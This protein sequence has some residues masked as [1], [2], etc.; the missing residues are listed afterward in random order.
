MSQLHRFSISIARLHHATSDWSVQTPL[1][2]M[3]TA[4]INGQG[5]VL[6]EYVKQ[7]LEDR[8]LKK[9]R[10]RNVVTA[11]SPTDLTL[12]QLSL[13]VPASEDGIRHSP[14]DL[15]FDV[16]RTLDSEEPAF[17]FVPALGLVVAAEEPTGL[18]DRLREEIRLELIRNER[19]G[20]ARSLLETQW[21]RDLTISHE[22]IALPFYT[23]SELRDFDDRDPLLPKVATRLTTTS[24]F[25]S[26][27]DEPMNALA[28]A[29]SGPRPSS[30]LVTGPSGVGK[31]AMIRNA[32][33]EVRCT[34][35]ANL[36]MTSA[37]RLISTLTGSIGWQQ[38]LTTLCGELREA[39]DLLYVRNLAELFEVGAYAG[40]E[41]TLADFL[42]TFI[43]RGDVVLI[44]EC[45]EEEAER[46]EAQHPGYI[47]LFRQIS[48]QEPEGEKLRS[49]VYE[50]AE[51][52]A[53][54]WNT[55]VRRAATDTLVRLQRRYAPYSGFP[56]TPIQTL[57]AVI[58]TE[59]AASDALPAITR[60]HVMQAYTE[61]TGFPRF[62]IDPEAPL[63]M[64]DVAEHFQS[65]L[66][67]QDAA[68]E[69]VIDLMAAVKTRLVP[70]HKPIA[71]L[72]FAGPTGVGKT[73]MAK[74]LASF[75]F[76][77]RERM[78]RFDMSEYADRASILQ[79]TGKGNG[80][81][82]GLL[83]GA[84]RKHPFSVLLFDEVEK[85][86]PLF[87]DLL[88]QILDAGRLTDA[89]GHVADFCSMVI[90][91]TSNIGTEEQPAGRFGF[92][93][94][95]DA[96]TT[97]VQ[98]FERAV[99]QH[100]RPELFNRID[101]VV[102]FTPLAESTVAKIIHRELDAIRERYGLSEREVTLSLPEEVIEW[103]SREGYN[104]TYGARHLKRTLHDEL[105]AP[106]ARELMHYTT[107]VP[108]SVEVAVED[109]ELTIAV[110]GR[111][112]ETDAAES[113]P[114]RKHTQRITAWRRV[115]QQIEEGALFV[116]LA[117][118]RDDLR[119]QHR[120]LVERRSRGTSSSVHQKIAK[121][122]QQLSELSDVL[123]G[124]RDTI[125]TLH[126]LERSAAAR[127]LRG[128]GTAE[129]A[130]DS[131]DESGLLTMCIGELGNGVNRLYNVGHSDDQTCVVAV[132]GQ[133]LS[134]VEHLKD[135]YIKTA[136]KACIDSTPY[137]VRLC[138]D[139]ETFE[140]IRQSELEIDSEEE[141]YA[142]VEV[143]M[144]GSAA[145]L[146]F[147]DEAGKHEWMDASTI[148]QTNMVVRVRQ[149]SITEYAREHRPS[150]IH[151]KSFFQSRS[152][153][154]VYA[155]R[156]IGSNK[157]HPDDLD[158]D[159]PQALYDQF[160]RRLFEEAMGS[161]TEQDDLDRAL[162]LT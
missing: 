67:G 41:T 29:I 162:R 60:D 30:V 52:T 6:A 158:E 125:D 93:R 37:T 14:V 91:M 77:D 114:L 70:A 16:V 69:T 13:S 24:H 61:A 12:T 152:T 21:F 150:T 65:R 40:N 1:M 5:S 116:T 88:L 136:N 126:E 146:L 2:D 68:T 15:A 106:M 110:E 28:N 59:A 31:S 151:R 72:L 51:H 139:A 129:D 32:W 142:G 36:W 8:L 137:V 44:T 149:G 85:A 47:D 26:G 105:V 57:E 23:P 131:E 127:L 97:L 55:T 54:S 107:D 81:D 133:P 118:E 115:A 27:V 3:G 154:R 75:M 161:E 38:N 102:P 113:T 62:M 112:N 121:V 130:T 155:E 78:L 100:F 103:L 138:S 135:L 7:K 98:H 9:G 124:L 132:Y 4:L 83:T 140:H 64:E 96:T 95:G 123:D 143:E 49:I 43:E 111:D 66:F 74:V 147:E 45:T 86:H 84:A 89:R 159:L 120:R 63:R 58:R 22:T 33:D 53:R 79:L 145:Y 11:L 101:R 94:D 148:H 157:V 19:V 119:K 104:P 80:R 156:K 92:Q 144:R 17:G 141:T 50:R 160:L 25:A 34:L 108:L 39:G 90:I 46:I 18:E 76:N 56:G 20:S 117:S 128:S 87:A 99:E 122:E 10:Y 82:T 42:R 35:H 48:M 109:E 73:E 153:R 71:S 134:L